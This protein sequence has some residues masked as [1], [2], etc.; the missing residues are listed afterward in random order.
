MRLDLQS[1]GKVFAVLDIATFD[2]VPGNSIRLPSL[3]PVAECLRS[4]GYAA[5]SIRTLRG[6]CIL[7][8][9]MVSR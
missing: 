3:D 6:R 5:A 2:F 4:Q 8:A 1:V 9:A 7:S